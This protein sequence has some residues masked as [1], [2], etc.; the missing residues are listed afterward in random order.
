MNEISEKVMILGL[1]MID[2]LV[3][4]TPE[5][6]ERLK[7]LLLAESNGNPRLLRFVH[8]VFDI[9]GAKRPALIEMKGAG[10]V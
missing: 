10:K 5:E 3:D 9:A 4:K 2:A 6:F 8:T 1:S 7:L